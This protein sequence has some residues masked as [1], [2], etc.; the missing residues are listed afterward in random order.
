[1]KI[2]NTYRLVTDETF[3]EVE[4]YSIEDIIVRLHRKLKA[5]IAEH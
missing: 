4:K 5:V 1:M 3:S 2:M